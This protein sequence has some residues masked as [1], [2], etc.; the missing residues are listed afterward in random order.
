MSNPLIMTPLRLKVLRFLADKPDGYNAKRMVE[1]LCPRISSFGTP[2]AWTKQGLARQ[3]GKVIKPLK[4]AGFVREKD[5]T[6]RMCDMN[7]LITPAGLALLAEHDAAAS[8]AE[9]EK[10]IRSGE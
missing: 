7:M 8:R 9:L 10:A 4:D 3:T 6:A 1:Q 2:L 5:W